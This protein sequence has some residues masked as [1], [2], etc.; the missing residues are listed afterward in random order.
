MKNEA[1][2]K[3]MVRRCMNELKKKK[4]E[5]DITKEDVDRAV[6]ITRVVNKEWCNGATYGGRNV[7]QINLS[8][9]QH[10]KGKHFQ[11]E[12]DAFNK[13]PVIGGRWC[14]TL[15]QS[16]WITVAHEVAHHVQYSKGPTCR[17]LKKHYRKPHGRG[18]QDIYT[19]LRSAV[20]NKL[21]PDSEGGI[22]WKKV[23]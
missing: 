14:E 13:C 1:K 6:K 18:F 15:D 9:W 19:I 3:R 7:I 8:Y 17:W 10:K 2:I 4:Y 5:L 12:Y 20:V 23:G 11:K 22:E 21:L 16:L